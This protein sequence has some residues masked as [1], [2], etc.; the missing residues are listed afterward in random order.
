MEKPKLL[1]FRSMMLS[2]S[3]AYESNYTLVKSPLKYE[4]FKVKETAQEYAHQHRTGEP[5]SHERQHK[6]NY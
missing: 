6:R 4:V 5:K 2:V 1:S 3:L